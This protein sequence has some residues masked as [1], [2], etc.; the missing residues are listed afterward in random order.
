[1]YCDYYGVYDYTVWHD[2]KRRKALV[3]ED[4]K[5]DWNKK[6]KLPKKINTRKGCWL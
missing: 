3:K 4:R 2:Q 5:R 1:M 6:V